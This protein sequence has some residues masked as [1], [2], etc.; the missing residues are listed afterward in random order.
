MIYSSVKYGSQLLRIFIREYVYYKQLA[1][2]VIY[3][4][5]GYLPEIPLNYYLNINSVTDG[6][7]LLILSN[8]H[9]YLYQY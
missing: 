9:T 4:V 3:Y 5:T 7:T 1:N 6:L 8:I 2:L